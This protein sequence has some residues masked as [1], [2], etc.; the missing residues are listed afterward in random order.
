MA[1]LGEGSNAIVWPRATLEEDE[2]IDPAEAPD[3]QR[4]MRIGSNFFSQ[5]PVRLSLTAE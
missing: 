4:L 1:S 3:N 5:P 2:D